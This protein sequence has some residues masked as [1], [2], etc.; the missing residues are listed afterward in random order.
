MRLC[1]KGLLCS[2]L[3]SSRIPPK[4]LKFLVGCMES[5][6]MPFDYIRTDSGEYQCPHCPFTK[7]NQSTVHMHIKA[8][9][10]GT[11]KHKCKHCPYECPARQTLE[12]HI[13]A[14]HP[15]HLERQV[16]EYSCPHD[17]CQF[18]CL[19]KGGLR[20]HYLL[21]H[22]SEYTNKYFGKGEKPE[23][24]VQCTHCGSQFQSKP[25]FIYHL[26]ACL[27]PEITSDTMVK[28]GLCI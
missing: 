6:Q 15:E 21:K 20:S 26:V 22:L 18:E 19:T 24:G 12:N 16:R 5:P 7:K 1:K 14:K 9:H 27:P 4:K 3:Y 23:D 17:D 10:S 8:K 28:K 11:F 13:A 25:S 2:I